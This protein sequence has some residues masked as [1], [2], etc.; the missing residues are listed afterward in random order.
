VRSGYL[1]TTSGTLVDMW[2]M[3]NVLDGQRIRQVFAGI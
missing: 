3:V 2:F 1:L